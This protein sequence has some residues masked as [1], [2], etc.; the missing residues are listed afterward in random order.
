MHAIG[1]G[2]CV[3]RR[4][5]RDTHDYPPSTD[6]LLMMTFAGDSTLMANLLEL[7]G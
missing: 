7:A 2:L 5:Q 3:R 4:R 1:F 6:L